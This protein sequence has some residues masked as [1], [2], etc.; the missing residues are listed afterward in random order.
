MFSKFEKHADLVTAMAEKSGTDLGRHLID[1]T[2][3]AQGLRAAVLTCTHCGNVSACEK[4][5]QDSAS[6]ATPDYC[7]NRALFERLN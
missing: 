5:L 2:L 7:L 6:T 3:G 4:H 1:G